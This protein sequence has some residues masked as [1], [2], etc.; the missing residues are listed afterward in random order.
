ML[1]KIVLYSTRRIMS[2]ISCLVA[3]RINA[4]PTF[5]N[6][7]KTDM[8]RSNIRSR[9]QQ[10]YKMNQTKDAVLLQR[11]YHLTRILICCVCES[12]E[13]CGRRLRLRWLL[14]LTRHLH[15]VTMT[16]PAGLAQE[17]KLH[18]LFRQTRLCHTKKESG[19]SIF[20]HSRF[21]KISLAH[22]T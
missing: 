9:L 2:G 19:V 15:D 16:L 4:E 3:K 6:V 13:R 17:R 1:D 5:K 7:L 11:T 22:S 14:L 10:Q 21:K 8:N 20:N 18:P 12:E